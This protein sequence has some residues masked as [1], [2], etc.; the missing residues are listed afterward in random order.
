MFEIKLTISLDEKTKD[1]L[2]RLIEAMNKETTIKVEDPDKNKE[3]TTAKKKA[4]AP[5]KATAAPAPVEEANWTTNNE[6]ES[7][8]EAVM[9]PKIEPQQVVGDEVEQ[10]DTPQE[11]ITIEELRAL[12]ASTKR[13]KG[14][15]AIKAILK[16]YG[17]SLLSDLDP[18][19][20]GEV[21]KKVRAL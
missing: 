16:G 15:D 8:R 21:A 18:S 5:I 3:D 7:A 17:V 20:Y 14:T 10:E 6:D 19:H 9:T 11:N 4:K 13:E 1:T 2:D 12:L